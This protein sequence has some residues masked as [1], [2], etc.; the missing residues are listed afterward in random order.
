MA[1]GQTGPITGFVG[2]LFIGLAILL[3]AGFAALALALGEPA[4][5]PIAIAG[6]VLL[7]VFLAIAWLLLH[8]LAR[9]LD[10]LALDVGIIAR[11]NPD[12]PPPKRDIDFD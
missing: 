4:A 11:E 5:T 8:R 6:G 12:E 10:R 7:A 3:A 1:R 9:P 2:S